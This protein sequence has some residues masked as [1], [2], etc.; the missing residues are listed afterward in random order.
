MREGQRVP[1]EAPPNPSDSSVQTPEGTPDLRGRPVAPSIKVVRGSILQLMPLPGW[2]LDEHNEC[3]GAALVELEVVY[4]DGTKDVGREILPFGSSLAV[5]L[6]DG[7]D[8]D[9]FYA[10]HALGDYRDYLR[11]A[12]EAQQ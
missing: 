4:P 12:G 1:P 8:H 11:R 2:M 7:V 6:P 9:A 3:L 5:R 10:I